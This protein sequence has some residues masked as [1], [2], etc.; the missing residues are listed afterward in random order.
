MYYICL[1]VCIL[2]PDGATIMVRKQITKAA[3]DALHSGPGLCTTFPETKSNMVSP[4]PGSTF[5]KSV[6]FACVG[7]GLS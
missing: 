7:T 4:V 5:F 6:E 2:D 1:L 3:G